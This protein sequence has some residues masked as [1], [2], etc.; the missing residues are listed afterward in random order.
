M[1]TGF[2]TVAS[3]MFMQQRSLNTIANNMA[4]GETTGYRSERVISTTFE[5]EML[6]RQERGQNNPIGKG[7][8]VRVVEDV[9]TNF[10]PSRLV[11]TDRPFDLAINGEGFFNISGADMGQQYVTRN[12]NFNVDSEGFLVLEGKGRVLG[13]KGEIQVGLDSEFKVAENGEIYNSKGRYVDKLLITQPRPQTKMMKLPNGMFQIDENP[14]MTPEQLQAM[15]TGD[16]IPQN[17]EAGM[18]QV[19]NVNIQQG[20]LEGSNVN[21]NQEMALMIETQRNFQSCS[22][23][24]QMIDSLNQKTTGIASL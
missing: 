2:Y 22:K 23:A 16:A 21:F 24:L 19:A 10:D 6:I 15:S 4:N 12:G 3:G 7:S 14:P 20:V 8:P 1:F 18:L 5:Q 17:P 9:P 11:Q 13:V